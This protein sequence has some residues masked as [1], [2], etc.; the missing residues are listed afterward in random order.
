VFEVQGPYKL[1]TGLVLIPGAGMGVRFIDRQKTRDKLKSFVGKKE[2]GVYVFA[3]RSQRHAGKPWYVGKNESS[4]RLTLVNEALSPDKLRKYALALGQQRGTPILYFLS[5]SDGRCDK[6][7]SLEDF[8][9]WLSRQKSP[10]LLNKKKVRLSPKDLHEHLQR[11][12]IRGIL[13]AGIGSG[14][15]TKAELSFREMIGWNTVMNVAQ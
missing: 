7:D 14:R 2:G 5:P 12:K 8:L 15:A 3:I 11:H 1:A 9:I 10:Q 6:V 13:G 4:A